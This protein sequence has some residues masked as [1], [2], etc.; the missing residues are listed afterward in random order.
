[1]IDNTTGK[2]PRSDQAIEEEADRESQAE[3]LPHPA[4]IDAEVTTRNTMGKTKTCQ[5]IPASEEDDCR[6]T[7]PRATSIVRGAGRK[8]RKEH[9]ATAASPTAA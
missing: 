1:V 2:Q 3:A 5:P 7:I 4:S 9:M 8:V 6:G